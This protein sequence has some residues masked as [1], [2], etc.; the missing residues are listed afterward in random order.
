MI[1]EDY[2]MRQIEIVVRMLVKL[3]FNKETTEY[4]IVEKMI[5]TEPDMIHNQ[6]IKLIDDRKI[7]EA[8]NLLFEKIEE[9]LEENAGGKVY[10]EI[11]V[12]FYSRLNLL[13]NKILDGCGFGREEIDEGVRAAADMYGIEL[14]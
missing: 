8:E 2:L 9:E 7:N 13:S 3:V 12:D 11:A 4:V 14:I 10:L 5:F 1:R 6:L